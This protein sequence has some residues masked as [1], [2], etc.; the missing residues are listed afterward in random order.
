MFFDKYL[1]FSI[2]LIPFVHFPGIIL[3]LGLFIVLLKMKNQRKSYFALVKSLIFADLVLLLL[4]SMCK[5]AFYVEIKGLR[6]GDSNTWSNYLYH[7][8]YYSTEY[9]LYVIL[10]NLI[11][12][13]SEHYTAIIKP[14]HY[15]NWIR[16]RYIICRLCAIWIIPGPLV[17]FE[18]LSPHKK[19]V[20][21]D[22][23]TDDGEHIITFVINID[24]KN[25]FRIPFVLV[26]FLIIA[27]TY[28]YIYFVVRKQQRLHQFQNQHAKNNKKALV[29]TVFIILS[30]FLCW[31]PP[32][33]AEI[34][35]Q[36]RNPSDVDEV[37]TL[38]FWR[39]SIIP[40]LIGVNSICDPLIY[41]VRLPAVRK[42]WK[43]KICCCLCHRKFKMQN[44]CDHRKISH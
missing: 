32:V 23:W 30:F 36:I 6:F 43:R 26:C 18:Y 40:L 20:E 10:L 24:W 27:I 9:L 41:A 2:C 39:N 12:L 14:L 31:A 5:I 44:V 4:F 42:V 13:A 25:T 22:K 34:W 35:F 17:F 21:I 7:I 16:H 8:C 38:Q 3:N 28:I 29:T 1:L 37:F 33:V 11:A 15:V 19:N